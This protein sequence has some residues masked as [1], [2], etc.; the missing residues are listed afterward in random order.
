MCLVLLVGVDALGYSG[1][2]EEKEQGQLGEGF[3][4]GRTGKKEGRGVRKVN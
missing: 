1:I 4:K 2:S 3:F